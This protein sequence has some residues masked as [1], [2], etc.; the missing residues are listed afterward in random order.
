MQLR[1]EARVE[2]VAEELLPLDLHDLVGCKT[3]R[4]D[5]QDRLRPNPSR[6]SQYQ[7]LTNR[8][9]GE[10]HNYLVGSLYNLSCSGWTYVGYGL[11]HNLKERLCPLE[12]LLITSYHD[13]ECSLYCSHVSPADG[14]VEHRS[15]P[16]LELLRQL[17]GDDGGDGAHVH[18]QGA[19]LDALKHPILPAKHIAHLR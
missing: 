18:N 14:S 4:E 12:V 16:L 10:R 7:S 11:S 2:G 5:L 1:P 15:S 19:F 6:R 17:L 3:A 13:R 9:Y 8:L